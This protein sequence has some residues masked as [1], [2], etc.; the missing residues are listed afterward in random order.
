[1]MHYLSLLSQEGLAVLN[2]QLCPYIV[3]H[4]SQLLLLLS[5]NGD[6]PSEISLDGGVLDSARGG[7]I[8]TAEVAHCRAHEPRAFAD[9]RYSEANFDSQL[10]L[11]LLK[12]G[13]EHLYLCL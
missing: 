8:S 10:L 13:E 5:I 2:L 9:Y 11:T 6:A 7:Q 4:S 3:H 1:M 12:K